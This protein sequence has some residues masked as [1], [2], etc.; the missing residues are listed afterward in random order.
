[1]KGIYTNNVIS[2]PSFS[3][4]LQKTQ[5]TGMIAGVVR[6]TNST[7]IQGATVTAG[8]FS[9]TTNSV[10]AYTL[11]L[12]IG[13]YSVTCSANGFNSQTVDGIIV[14]VNQTTTLNFT[15]ISTA[16]EDEVIPVTATALLGN[17]PNP[18]NPETVITYSVKDPAPV[19][20]E[21]FN[22]KGQRVRTLVSADQP[23]GWYKALWNGTDDRGR[24]VS[25]GV[26]MYRMTAGN[27]QCSRKMILMQ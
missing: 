16:N 1:V 11:V 15:M 24:P 20:I 23:T 13:T 27:Y 10:G 8:G 2:V 25:S 4:V 19:R 7:P 3:N 22:A 18:F 26:Y 12:P 17:Y 6:R 9:A 21:I 5:E 14:N